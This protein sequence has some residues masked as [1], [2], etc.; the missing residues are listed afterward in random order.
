MYSQMAAMEFEL[1][2]FYCRISDAT[3]NQCTMHAVTSAIPTSPLGEAE[4]HCTNAITARPTITTST[5]SLRLNYDVLRIAT[6]I[7]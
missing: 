7:V 2:A 3:P 5:S 4:C 6:N 1:T